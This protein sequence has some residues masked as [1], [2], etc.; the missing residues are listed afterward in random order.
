MQ[1]D[2]RQSSR[3]DRRFIVTDYQ[4]EHFEF[5][6]EGLDVNLTGL[7]FWVSDSELFMPGQSLAL[8]VRAEDTQEFYALDSVEVVHLREQDGLVLCGCHITQVS[9][10]QLLAHHRLVML[11]E[12]A[13][14]VSMA[15]SD[16]REFDF[17]NQ[18]S[19]MSTQVGDYQQAA[20]A[21]NLAVEELTSG[22]Q[23][24]EQA[25]L[26]FE[27]SLQDLLSQLEQDEQQRVLSLIQGFKR[28][29]QQQ[30]SRNEQVLALSLLAKMLVHT[31]ETQADRLAW[32]TLIRD[33]E[34]RF[35]DERL[36]LAYDL[37][38]QGLEAAEAL[39]RAGEEIKVEL[40]EPNA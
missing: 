1:M 38:H 16:L 35:L 40:K 21:L 13:A 19:V 18:T 8:R 26:G 7:S 37:M 22:V 14:E 34:T 25:W 9:S 2:Q 15:D 24:D 29:H 31:P 39:A 32:Q 28:F 10:D 4:D 5:A 6:F 23:Q 3:F 33:F 36:L 30:E 20:F 12:A 17:N 11:T 27:H